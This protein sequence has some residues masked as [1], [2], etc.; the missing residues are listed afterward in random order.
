M[1]PIAPH[2]EVESL[3]TAVQA[4]APEKLS[5]EKQLLSMAM[6][7]GTRAATRDPTRPLACPPRRTLAPERHGHHVVC[8]RRCPRQP[9]VSSTRHHLH[10]T[11]GLIVPCG[12]PDRAPAARLPPLPS[13]ACSRSTLPLP[14]SAQRQHA[15]AR[16]IAPQRCCRHGPGSTS[17][18]RRW[19]RTSSP[20]A[21]MERS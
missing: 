3:C 13:F 8:L 10:F 14:A 4:E 5:R 21:T 9:P 6:R 19:T 1:P 20:T 7:S 2:A 15:L 18:S 16:R 11:Q 17:S 12:V